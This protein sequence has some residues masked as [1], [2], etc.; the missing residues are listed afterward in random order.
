MQKIDFGFTG[1][2][3]DLSPAQYLGLRQ[4]MLSI[5]AGYPDFQIRWHHGDCVGADEVS[6]GIAREFGFH[7]VSHPPLD[8]SKR[9]FCVADEYRDPKPYLDRN[10]DIAFEGEAGLIVAPKGSS[11]EVRSGT[12]STVRRA[13]KHDRKILYVWPNGDLEWEVR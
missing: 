9:A 10:E 13:R 5:Q 12:W 4:A 11:E 2:Q 8:E 6:H 3:V 1:T 7:I